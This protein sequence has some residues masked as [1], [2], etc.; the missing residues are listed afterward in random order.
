[1]HIVSLQV[2]SEAISQHQG[3]T[4]EAWCGGDILHKQIGHFY[5]HSSEED[6]S[7]HNSGIPLYS[8]DN[9]I[10]SGLPTFINTIAQGLPFPQI[11]IIEWIDSKLQFLPP[12]STLIP[13]VVSTK[14]RQRIHS[15][16]FRPT[17]RVHVGPKGGFTLDIF[18]YFWT[19]DML[20]FNMHMQK[21]RNGLK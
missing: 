20:F 21:Y 7:L 15:A 17:P 12:S 2:N 5:T 10:F 18:W 11:S 3:L 1:M 6:H 16:T 14:Q 19:S 9:S 8:F 4:Q 13:H